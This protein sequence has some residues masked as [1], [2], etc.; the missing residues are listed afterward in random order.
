MKTKLKWEVEFEERIKGMSN[1]DLFNSLL[2]SA[3][4]FGSEFCSD[5]DDKEYKMLL[6]QAEKRLKRWLNK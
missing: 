4:Y 2:D 5:R 3:T 1:R 6:E